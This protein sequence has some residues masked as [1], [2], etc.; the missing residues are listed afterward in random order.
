MVSSA[1]LI[2]KNSGMRYATAVRRLRS[3]AEELDRHARLW[4]E[5]LLT[6]AYAYGE[7]LEG[8]EEIAMVEV[9]LVLDL[10]PPQVTWYAEPPSAAAF[11]HLTRL[12]KVPARWCWRPALWPVW[13]HK[14]R[15]PVR[16]WSLD[17]PDEA[18]LDAL[19]ERRFDRL[20][21]L[22]PTP[23]EELEQL[24][25]ELAASLTHLR[26]VTGAYWDREWRGEHKGL[27]AYPEHYLWRAAEGYLDLLR[28]VGHARAGQG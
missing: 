15:G 18:T 24:E 8:P 10:P 12:D 1:T 25:E 21:R 6:A 16:F 5:P 23:A 28:A 14:I 20:Q 26:Q 19:D 22:V 7:L 11:A 3:I 4:E 9:A 27:G 2:G 13:N 17:G